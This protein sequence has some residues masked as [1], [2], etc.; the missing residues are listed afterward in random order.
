MNFEVELDRCRWDKK[1]V[2]LNIQ[3]GMEERKK[4]KLHEEGEVRV[5]A[6]KCKNLSSFCVVLLNAYWQLLLLLYTVKC[7]H[8]SSLKL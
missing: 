3:F 1:T 2:Y 6:A 4:W 8:G 7:S 5:K